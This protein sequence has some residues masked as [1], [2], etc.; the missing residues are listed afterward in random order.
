MDLVDE[1]VRCKS[2]SEMKTNVADETYKYI[3]EIYSRIRISG[4]LK[5]KTGI[6]TGW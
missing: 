2:P 3:Q 1:R 6:R 4:I 5:P